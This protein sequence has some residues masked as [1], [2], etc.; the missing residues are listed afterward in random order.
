LHIGLHART[1]VT[2]LCGGHGR[3]TGIDHALDFIDRTLDL[4]QAHPEALSQDLLS[5]SAHQ[6]E[7]DILLYL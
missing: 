1:P 3:S 4:T 5:C 2:H 7:K 6:A